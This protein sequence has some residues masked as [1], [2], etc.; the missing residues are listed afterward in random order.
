MIWTYWRCVMGRT[1][2]ISNFASDILSTLIDGTEKV[3]TIKL[4]Q[5]SHKFSDSVETQLMRRDIEYTELLNHFVNI[6]KTRNIIREWAKWITSICILLTSGILLYIFYCIINRILQEEETKQI[7]D[8][9]PL[10]ITS[11]VS[12][13]SVVI[14]VPLTMLKYLFSNKED[15]YITQIILH[16]QDHDTS[17]RQW[18]L[19]YSN[20][21]KQ[22]IHSNIEEHEKSS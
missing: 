15:D 11:I 10:L 4:K 17:G 5:D 8:A 13:I 9:I 7:L 1:E 16:T 2:K 22:I 3:K 21:D 18:T 14:A 12:F 19:D 20:Q 6:S